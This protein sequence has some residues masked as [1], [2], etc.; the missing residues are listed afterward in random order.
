VVLAD[1]VDLDALRAIDPEIFELCRSGVASGK[2]S[3][4]DA[5]LD[6]QVRRM[7]TRFETDD[8][9]HRTRR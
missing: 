5:T 7:D 2:P 6:P 9:T 4:V 8:L 3:Y 1:R